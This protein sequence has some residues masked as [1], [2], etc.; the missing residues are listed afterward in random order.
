MSLKKTFNF[1]LQKYYQIVV[2]EQQS[3]LTDLF[4]LINNIDMLTITD[5]F[6]VPIQVKKNKQQNKIWYYKKQM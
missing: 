3:F 6:T 1:E 4:V 5:F 2:I